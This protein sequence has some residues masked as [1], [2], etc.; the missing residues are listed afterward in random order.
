MLVSSLI[1][2]PISDSFGR[3]W[4]NVFLVPAI[5]TAICTVIFVIGFRED[6]Q[7]AGTPAPA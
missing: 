3:N 2:G 4:H 1:A 7:P 5:L 6:R